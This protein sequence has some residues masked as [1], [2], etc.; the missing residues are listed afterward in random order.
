[1]TYLPFLLE[2]DIVMVGTEAIASIVFA[3]SFFTIRAEKS[4]ASPQIFYV[5]N[6]NILIFRA[7]DVNFLAIIVYIKH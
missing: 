1:M 3:N 7:K 4:K 6:S 2:R 5:E